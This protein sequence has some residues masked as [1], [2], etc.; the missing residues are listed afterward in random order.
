[1]TAEEEQKIRL[2]NSRLKQDIQLTFVKTRHD[3]TETI[4]DF[5]R[6]LQKEAPKIHIAYETEDSDAPPVLRIH[7]GIHYRSVPHR[8][9][10]GTLSQSPYMDVYRTGSVAAPSRVDRP[11]VSGGIETLYCG[12]V[13]VLPGRCRETGS[14]CHCQ[15]P[16]PVDGY[17][18]RAVHGRSQT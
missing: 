1:M 4:G 12:T 18:C 10:T 13:P 17:R 9:G 16:G 15:S 14:P 5:C 6:N 8:S 7:P 11:G 2:F 3:A